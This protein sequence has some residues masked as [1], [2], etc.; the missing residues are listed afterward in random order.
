MWRMMLAV[1]EY[2]DLRRQ[3]AQ[4][5]NNRLAFY[6]LA[7]LI[8]YAIVIVVLVRAYKVLGKVNQYIAFRQR[9]KPPLPPSQQPGPFDQ[10]QP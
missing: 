8:F 1:G 9:Q 10:M 5:Q 6:Q 7:V 3:I 4:D 2:E